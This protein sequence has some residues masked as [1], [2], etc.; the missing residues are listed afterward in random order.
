MYGRNSVCHAYGA[1][2][3]VIMD[4]R[5]EDCRAACNMRRGRGAKR[6]WWNPYAALLGGPDPG[7]GRAPSAQV[8]RLA[9]QLDRGGGHG[10][11]GRS[12]PLR[13]PRS[14]FHCRCLKRSKPVLVK[15]SPGLQVLEL[16]E[17]LPDE[18]KL[19]AGLCFN[20]RARHGQFACPI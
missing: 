16:R 2:G 1:P 11:I 5:Y 10:R 19:T 8:D 12:Y 3:P 4:F 17:A 7:A 15:V 20:L 18:A 6:W 13:L 14:T 9:R